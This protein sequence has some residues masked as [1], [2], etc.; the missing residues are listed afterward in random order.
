MESAPETTRRVF[1]ALWPAATER[2]AL[3]AWQAPLQALCGGKAMRDETLHCTLAFLGEVP[4]ARLE[5]LCL[6]AQE[7][8]SQPF[9]L[10]LV[11]AHYWGHNHIVYAAPATTPDE[12]VVLVARL[13]ESLR[14]H[15]FHFEQRPYKPHVTLLRHAQWT[16][17]PLPPMPSVRW[18]CREFVLVQS[19]GDAQGARY[20][21]LCRFGVQA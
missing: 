17:A 14:K 3:S 2:A 1:F 13:E 8:D 21:V 15:A 5:A 10:D 16:D 19:L 11:G 12:L 18:R 4:E 7:L 9:D 20:E 6:I